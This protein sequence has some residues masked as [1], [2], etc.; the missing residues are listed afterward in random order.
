MALLPLAG[1]GDF[2]MAFFVQRGLHFIQAA[3]EVFFGNIAKLEARQRSTA[4]RSGR[5]NSFPAAEL[6]LA[7]PY[8]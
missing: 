6:P 4:S 7:A 5:R 1:G 3:G 8:R 2:R